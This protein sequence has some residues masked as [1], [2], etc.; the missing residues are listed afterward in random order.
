MEFKRK[1]YFDINTPT[2][3]TES[4]VTKESTN[5]DKEFVNEKNLD[6]EKYALFFN[7]YDKS[8][9]SFDNKEKIK[10]D[11]HFWK[12]IKKEKIEFIFPALYQKYKEN[13][14]I[15]CIVN[16]S[17]KNNIAKLFEINSSFEFA[18][19][20]VLEI[21]IAPYEISRCYV[22]DDQNNKS[23]EILGTVVVASKEES[24]IKDKIIYYA[25]FKLD[26]I[27]Y[28][29]EFLGNK[30][31][32][33]LFA[34]FVISIIKDGKTDLSIFDNPVIPELKDEK[35][36]LDEAY[37]DKD[38]GKYL[39]TLPSRYV[40]ESA[41][42]FINQESNYLSSTWSENYNDIYVVVSKISDDDLNKIVDISDVEKYDV[43]LYEIPYGDSIPKEIASIFHYPIFKIDDLTV[44]VIKKRQK[45]DE[46]DETLDT[47]S[48][49]VLFED[50]V[51]VNIRCAEGISADE[52]YKELEKIK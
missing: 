47:A 30:G 42:R 48:F 21:K 50:G 41:R 28:S 10:I 7:I 20:N 22:F 32:E 51:V 16:Y 36:D 1:G 27:Y 33:F 34:D 25:D 43:S 37:K 15:K 26:D 44:D 23:S 5:E 39:I 19:N 9:M 8:E 49:G 4:N 45:Q 31:Q 24:S 29:L 38:F 13:S 17:S 18:D 2:I 3:E 46:E 35:I 40:F 6:S 12:E 11:G 52:L 14:Q